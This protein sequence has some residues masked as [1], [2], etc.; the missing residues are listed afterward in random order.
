LHDRIKVKGRTNNLG[1][2]V[3]I[4]RSGPSITITTVPGTMAKRYTKYLTKKFL[5]KNSIREYLRV[6]ATSKT[7]YAIKYFDNVV[8]DAEEED[9]E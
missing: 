9:E 6:V 8:D 7:T 5:K 1:S 4:T 3:S 2:T